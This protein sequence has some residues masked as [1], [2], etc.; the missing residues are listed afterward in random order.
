[1]NIPHYIVFLE[2]CKRFYIIKKMKLNSG[3]KQRQ[4]LKL[5]GR[6]KKETNLTASCWLLK[7][8]ENNYFK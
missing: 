8:T 1:M 4:S 7:V 2:S 3:E 6:L 5:R